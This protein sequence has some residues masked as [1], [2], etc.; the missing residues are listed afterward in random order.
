M[1]S[2]VLQ[3]K[4]RDI[5]DGSEMRLLKWSEKNQEIGDDKEKT[6]VS[7]SLSTVSLKHYDQVSLLH[8]LNVSHLI[9]KSYF[10]FSATCDVLVA[11]IFFKLRFT[12][13]QKVTHFAVFVKCLVKPAQ[14]AMET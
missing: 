1:N 10:S 12:F 8:S 6:A 5:E 4:L 14:F 9:F 2:K 3:D 7:S 13:A 11:P